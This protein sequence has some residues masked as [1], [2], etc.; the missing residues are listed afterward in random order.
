[1]M[2]INAHSCAPRQAHS[3]LGNL[4]PPK[5]KWRLMLER[6]DQLIAEQK[7]L[8]DVLIRL[9][10]WK[11]T[12]LAEAAHLAPSTVNK[13]RKASTPTALSYRTVTKL[14]DATEKRLHAMNAGR[15][16]LREFASVR[17]SAGWQDTI[18]AW[19][20]SQRN[21]TLSIIVIG[22]VGMGTFLQEPEWPDGKRYDLPVLNTLLAEGKNHYGLE[23]C[24]A[25]MDKLYPPGS[26]LICTP[27]ADLGREVRSGERV[28][29]HICRDDGQ[30][31]PEVRQYTVD[32]QGAHWLVPDS[33]EP[34]HPSWPVGPISATEMTKITAVV[35]GSYRRE[36]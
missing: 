13:F 11:P 4:A 14:L 24:G 17:E 15:E 32:R 29:C 20:A 25:S 19:E 30:V 28:V 27:V 22:A 16:Q 3:C 36:P 35:I 18:D 2:R 1:M 26:V 12:N 31:R 6:D 33:T 23:V 10:N 21:A 7:R 9:G 34:G 8:L 5:G